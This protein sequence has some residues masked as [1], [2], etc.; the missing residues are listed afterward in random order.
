MNNIEIK[1][2]KINILKIIEFLNGSFKINSYIS[3]EKEKNKPLNFSVVLIHDNIIINIDGDRPK[4][5]I[6]NLFSA[7]ITKVIL[8][9]TSLTVHGTACG[10][11]VPPLTIP[12]V[13]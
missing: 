1:D 12:I 4:I 8:K 5:K 10:I 13:S 7:S 6:A 9:E 2:Q 3:I 11:P